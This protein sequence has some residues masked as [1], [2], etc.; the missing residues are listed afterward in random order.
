MAIVSRLVY[1]LA[2]AVITNHPMVSDLTIYLAHDMGLAIG[3]ELR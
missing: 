1:Q 3:A 2:F